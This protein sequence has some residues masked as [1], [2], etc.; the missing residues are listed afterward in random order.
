[1]HLDVARA[2]CGKLSPCSMCA[3]ADGGCAACVLFPCRCVFGVQ[4]EMCSPS[5]FSPTWRRRA[6]GTTRCR[7]SAASQPPSPLHLICALWAASLPAAT[8]SARSAPRG[9]CTGVWHG[10]HVRYGLASLLEAVPPH[11]PHLRLT[12]QSPATPHTHTLACSFECSLGCS[13]PLKCVNGKFSDVG[14]GE[15]SLCPAGGCCA[16]CPHTHS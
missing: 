15:C 9:T 7:T 10:C 5:G 12:R 13:I 2:L 8:L 16:K 6:R 4:L 3:E 1:M 14:A 11:D